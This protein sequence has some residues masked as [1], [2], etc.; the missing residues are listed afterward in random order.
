MFGGLI[1]KIVGSAV[2]AFNSLVDELKDA[3]GGNDGDTLAKAIGAAAYRMSAADG[4]V[5]VSEVKAFQDFIG[6][7]AAWGEHRD[8][9]TGTFAEIREA[10]TLM[11]EMG[12]D[13]ANKYIGAARDLPGAHLIA[14]LMQHIARADGEIA[15]GEKQAQKDICSRLGLNPSQYE[16]SL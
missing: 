4:H 9:I 3:F 2:S 12:V 10:S 13:A 6:A 8:T 1:K 5:D 7:Q 16:L 14:R 11:P 15:D